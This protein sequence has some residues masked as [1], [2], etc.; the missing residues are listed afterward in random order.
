MVTDRHTDTITYVGGHCVKCSLAD[1][2]AKEREDE[3]RVFG[4][5]LAVCSNYW[6]SVSQFIAYNRMSCVCIDSVYLC[7]ILNKQHTVMYH[8]VSVAM[9]AI[10]HFFMC[11]V[12]CVALFCMSRCLFVSLSG[13]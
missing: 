9:Q 13:L 10:F 6:D 1:S 2:K 3:M 5:I 7:D 11:S 4:L 12:F 8:C